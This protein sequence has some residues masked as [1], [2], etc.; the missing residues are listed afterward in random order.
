MHVCEEYPQNWNSLVRVYSFKVCA[1]YCVVLAIVL[2]YQA[3]HGTLL[4]ASGVYHGH[5]CYNYRA[6]TRV[7]VCLYVHLLLSG[8]FNIYLFGITV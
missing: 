7:C 6:H 3:L 8:D 5:L 2:I 1:L 4:W